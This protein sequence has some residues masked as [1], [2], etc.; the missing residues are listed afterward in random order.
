MP[1]ALRIYQLEFT[2]NNVSAGSL[3]TNLQ[4]YAAPIA[5]S[6]QRFIVGIRLNE[7]GLRDLLGHFYSNGP[8]I[9]R[10]E[11]TDR[12]DYDRAVWTQINNIVNNAANANIEVDW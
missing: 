9:M 1:Q 3:H 10:V 6:G 4:T 5:L 2:Q 8:A 7:R 11:H 12:D